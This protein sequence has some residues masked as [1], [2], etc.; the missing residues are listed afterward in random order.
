MEVE[1]GRRVGQNDFAVVEVQRP[2]EQRRTTNNHGSRSSLL[3]FKLE[4]LKMASALRN[5]KMLPNSGS[6]E[7]ARQRVFDFFR[8][9][10]RS[11]SSVMEIYNLYDVTSVAQLAAPADELAMLKQVN[12]FA[13]KGLN[14]PRKNGFARASSMSPNARMARIASLENMLS[15]SSNSLV[16]MPSQ[17]SKE[18]ERERAFSNRGRWNQLR[19]MGEAK[20]FLQYMFNSVA[21]ASCRSHISAVPPS[22]KQQ[23]FRS[24]IVLWMVA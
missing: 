7:E 15:I 21:D 3:S 24:S 23:L 12:E 19:S 14:P 6:V 2:V 11:L 10:C 1:D 20:N 18:E 17:L 13:A 8:A 22:R 9:V 5:V 16:A 4:K